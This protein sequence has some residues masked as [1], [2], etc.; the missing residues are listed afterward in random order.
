MRALSLLPLLALA[1][2]DL[3]SGVETVGLTLYG[4]DGSVAATGQLQ[5]DEPARPGVRTDGTYTLD[6][7]GERRTGAILA[8]CSEPPIREDVLTIRLDPQ[9]ADGGVAL[10]GGCADGLT[11]GTWE[12]GSIVGPVASGRFEFEA[13]N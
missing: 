10:Y 5:F 4:E 13:G 12:V 2:C 6:W 3:A 7:S 8:E 1:A 11:G 9:T